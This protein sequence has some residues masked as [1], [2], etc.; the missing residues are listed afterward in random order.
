MKIC[1]VS[2]T[3]A[4]Q[5]E[6]GAE[7]SARMGATELARHHDV[8]VLAL[9]Q[10]GDALAPPGE[11]RTPDGIRVVRIPWRNSYLPGPRKAAV[12]ALRRAEWHLRAALGAVCVKGL[13]AFLKRENFDL[14][15]AQ[16]STRMQPALFR[17]T[18]QLGLPL[19]LHLRDYAL[20]CPRSSMFRRGD[21]CDRPCIDCRALTARMRASSAAG[22]GITAIAVS[23][24]LRKRFLR[25]GVLADADWHVLHNTNTCI[26]HFATDIVGRRAAASERFTFGYLGAL[27]EEK[28][29][30][31][32]IRAF[33]ALPRR[34]G[35][36]LL[37]AGRGRADYEAHLK[38]LAA[39]APVE[40]MGFVPPAEVYRRADAVVVPSRWHEPQS[41]ILVEA[42]VYG[43]PVIGTERGG[44]PEILR[45]HG[46]GWCYDPDSVGALEALLSKALDIGQ[47]DWWQ[48]RDTIF[49]GISGFRGTAGDSDYY[50]RLERI[51]CQAA[52]ARALSPVA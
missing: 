44:T 23:D 15:Y 30:E 43:V 32:L 21:N 10:E 50:G 34:A 6:G 22:A 25:N 36:R 1:I 33:V 5:E 19:C 35:A 46:T 45:D 14:V 29:I 12:G 24:A 51:L 39:G 42:A 41:R 13:T 3:F 17:A 49:P 28:G 18:Q 8:A 52:G 2:Q 40:F 48:S 37:V 47:D 4:P 16:N 26:S 11:S 9:G 20:L 7:I 31:E 27:A 38:S